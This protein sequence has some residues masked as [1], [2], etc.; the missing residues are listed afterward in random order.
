MSR[1]HTHTRL[2]FTLSEL[3]VSAA[4]M[5]LVVMG[6]A[7]SI[8][9]AT[10]ALP[11][12]DNP[13][14]I[15]FDN[16]AVADQIVEELRYAIAITE[17]SSN[18]IAFVVHDRN[19]DGVPERIRYAWSG[20]AGDPL[21]REYN[22]GSAVEVAK[23]VSEFALGY[24]IDTVK[25]EYPGPSVETPEQLFS[26]VPAGALSNN[27]DVD[28]DDWVG[29]YIRPT[30]PE[31]TESWKLTRVEFEARKHGPDDGEISV[32]L[33]NAGAWNLPGGTLLAEQPMLES[34]LDSNYRVESFTFDLPGL[35]PDEG[36]CLVLK[37]V[38][39]GGKMARIH[40]DDDG[41]VNGKMLETGIFGWEIEDSK[42]MVHSV[43]GTAMTP[44]PTQ[45]AERRY[46]T[47]VRVGMQVSN[48]PATRV[49]TTVPAL[50]RPELLSAFW[51]VDFEN[52]PTLDGNADEHADWSVRGSTG[53]RAESLSGGVWN[54]DSI[55][56]T[57]P[58]NSFKKLTTVNVRFRNTSVGGLGAMFLINV[59]W[60]GST[61]S[62]LYAQ[63][64][65]RN[66][67]T[68]T[69]S[70]INKL[71]TST[72]TTLA[73]VSG[74]PGDFVDLR[75]LI[76]PGLDTVNVQVNGLDEGTYLYNKIAP[77]NS[78]RIATLMK[79]GSNAEIDSISIRVGEDNDNG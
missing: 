27:E 41:V 4:I 79:V 16:A 32:Q 26:T 31:G 39:G 21:T 25:E 52:D 30:L 53:F 19:G 3:T 15:S 68:Q 24:Y 48:D 63:L 14:Q 72:A 50:N 43:Y 1:R 36:V 60:S 57:Y 23:N 74:L 20:T 10:Q 65:L 38:S 66:D 28:N 59:D 58:D 55:L 13:S 6:I 37:G 61:C 45:I 11:D 5:G 18:V 51:E 76:D 8:M 49:V 67:G 70:L 42:N 33:W 73:T 7:S 54:V 29:Q 77:Y 9:V 40:Y 75:L 71:G 34:T 44:G 47:A 17:R 12:E 64:R 35:M 2:G 78:D 62:Y 56:D 46:L 22:G 69:L